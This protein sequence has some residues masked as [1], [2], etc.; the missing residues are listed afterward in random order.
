MTRFINYTVNKGLEINTY[1]AP[2]A[3]AADLEDIAEAITEGREEDLTCALEGHEQGLLE[4]GGFWAG[5]NVSQETL[6][7]L[8]ALI[9][10]H[11]E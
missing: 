6:E 4:S 2:Q 8:H 7:E 10:E 11:A 9:S 5:S 3:A 1:R